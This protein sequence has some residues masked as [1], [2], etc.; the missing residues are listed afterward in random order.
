[1]A[2]TVKISDNPTRP[3]TLVSYMHLDKYPMRMLASRLAFVC[4]FSLAVCRAVSAQEP[5]L[6]LDVPD[7]RGQYSLGTLTFTPSTLALVGHDT[8]M[9]RAVGAPA[10]GEVFDVAQVEA[11]WKPGRYR[12]S[13][14]AAFEYERELRD[15]RTG[16]Y[17]NAQELNFYALTGRIRPSFVFTRHNHFAPPTDFSGF[18]LGLKSRRIETQSEGRLSTLVGARTRLVGFG[19]LAGITYDADARYQGVSLQDNLNRQGRAVGASLEHSISRQTVVFE[20]VEVGQEHYART[21]LRNGRE[22][23]VGIG[24]RS[25]AS[26]LLSGGAFIGRRVYSSK[27]SELDNFKGLNWNANI[28]LTRPRYLVLLDARRDNYAS[29]SAGLG[30]YVS[31]G[32]SLYA[33]GHI[34]TR[35]DVYGTTSRYGL[36]YSAAAAAVVSRY[37]A[38][39]AGLVYRFSRAL[40][41]AT[42]EFYAQRGSGALQGQRFTT[43]VQIGGGRI[44]R[45]DRPLPGER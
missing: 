38:N 3:F 25:Q 22:S 17:N 13:G 33:S 15:S 44:R 39:G 29:Y 5:P 18:E 19:R 8:N 2:D 16:T 26:A 42:S 10:S 40:V 31:T 7:E 35:I 41:G 30:Q 12:L 21:P 6:T 32:G 28:V 27:T 36:S 37:T 45:L 9:M 34:S 1:M 11:W 23:F 24:V 43:Y 14:V 4:V 20:S